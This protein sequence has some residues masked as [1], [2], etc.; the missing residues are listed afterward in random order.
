MKNKLNKHQKKVRKI[1]IKKL[2]LDIAILAIKNIQ[3]DPY[4][5]IILAPSSRNYYM[6]ALMRAFHW[7]LSPQGHDYWSEINYK[8]FRLQS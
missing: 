1:L 2:P 6:Y 5:K 3:N 7:D 4:G 8:Y